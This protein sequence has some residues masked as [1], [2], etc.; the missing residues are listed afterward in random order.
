MNKSRTRVYCVVSCDL[1][2]HGHV[3]FFQQAREYGDELI[4]GVCSD[5][6]VAQYKSAPIMSLAE[7]AEIVA[8][9][10][11]VDAV[12]L[13][14]PPYVSREWIREHDIDFVVAGGDYLEDSLASYYRQPEEAGILRQAAYTKGISSSDIIQRCVIQTGDRPEAP[15]GLRHLEQDSEDR[16]SVERILMSESIYGTGYQSTNGEEFSGQMLQKMEARQGDRV[17]DL[18]C[19]TGGSA[20]YLAKTYNADVVGVDLSQA[21]IDLCRQRAAD[22]A[23]ENLAYVCHDIRELPFDD[24]FDWFWT[25]DVLIYVREKTECLS[26]AAKLLKP[27]RTSAVIDFCSGEGRLSRQFDD[28]MYACDYYL[29]S[30]DEYHEIL[31]D[32]GLDIVEVV[33]FTDFSITSMRADIE[34]FKEKK[35]NFVSRYGEKPYLDLVDRWEKKINF[36]TDR[37]MLTVCFL[38]SPT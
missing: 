8:A 9:C 7:R 4:V 24:L 23:I 26:N 34:R 6:D 17:L 28:H 13:N 20:Q 32:A 30:V 22:A 21:N 15:D 10:R 2:H 19:G 14:A 1:F 18:G 38:V 36:C 12:I 31:S 25:R 27:G 11:Y 29:A 35:D 5:D 16:Y 33:D 3:R 37:E